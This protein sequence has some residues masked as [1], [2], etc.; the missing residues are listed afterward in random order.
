MNLTI[1][2][3]KVK[4]PYLRC[5]SSFFQNGRPLYSSRRAS[6]DV[7]IGLGRSGIMDFEL[8]SLFNNAILV[9]EKYKSRHILQPR[10]K[11]LSE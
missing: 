2:N 8:Q 7:N 10:D 11:Y 3:K 6:W 5:T 9:Q 4:I 1:N